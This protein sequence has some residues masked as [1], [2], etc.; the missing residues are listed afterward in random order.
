[1]PLEEAGKQPEDGPAP[2]GSAPLL[3]PPSAE[4]SAAVRAESSE[5]VEPNFQE[6]ARWYVASGDGAQQFDSEMNV[7]QEGSSRVE[8]SS[9]SMIT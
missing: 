4:L 8:A 2:H 6:H 1:M 9:Y 7:R 5:M 3:F